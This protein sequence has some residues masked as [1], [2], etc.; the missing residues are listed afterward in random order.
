MNKIERYRNYKG[1]MR[2]Y[3]AEKKYLFGIVK[4]VLHSLVAFDGNR[5]NDFTTL[6]VYV[7]GMKVWH[8]EEEEKSLDDEILTSQLSDQ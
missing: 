6:D 4:R 3:L 1:E 5:H 8:Q 7:F 2:E